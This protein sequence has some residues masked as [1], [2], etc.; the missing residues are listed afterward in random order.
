MYKTSTLLQIVSTQRDADGAT[1]QQKST[2]RAT[3]EQRADGVHLF[4]DEDDTAVHLHLQE[5]SAQIIRTGAMR[6]QLALTPERDHT[7]Q[8]D[9]PIGSMN[10]KVHTHDVQTERSGKRMTARLKYDV[11]LEE[12]F[13]F[14]NDL[15]IVFMLKE[16]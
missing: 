9:T 12:A 6:L 4:Y 2:H 8:Y 11:Y 5:C 7:S 16:P 10:M 3:L 14:H 13:A 1:N 15:R